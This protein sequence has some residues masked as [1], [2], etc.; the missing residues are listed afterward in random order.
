LPLV[1]DGANTASDTV[2]SEYDEESF[3]FPGTWDTDSR[4]CL[5]ASSPRPCTILAAIVGVET[6]AR[7]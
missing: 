1:R 7:Y 6:N 4:L 3:A 2:Y 5:Q